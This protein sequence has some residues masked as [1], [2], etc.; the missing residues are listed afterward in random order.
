M[1]ILA[2]EDIMQRSRW[3]APSMEILFAKISP[4]SVGISGR[5]RF[6]K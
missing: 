5:S 6:T 3:L 1:R 4:G 2:I